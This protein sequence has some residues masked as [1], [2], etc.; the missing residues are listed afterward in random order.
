MRL[1]R[2]VAVFA[3]LV[4]VAGPAHADLRDLAARVAD[5]FRL[6]G[7]E[8]TIAP[9]RFLNDDETANIAL[10]DGPGGPCVSVAILGARGMSFRARLSVD[11]EN[12]SVEEGRTTGAS[13]AGALLLAR[14][15]SNTTGRVV[16]TSNA[17]RGAVEIVVARSKEAMASLTAIIP[18]RG[19]GS[20]LHQ[21]MV[22]PGELPALVP[23][24][25]RA[26]VAEARARRDG[27]TIDPRAFIIATSEGS[28]SAPIVLEPACHR[29]ELFGHE[30]RPKAAGRRGR[31]DLDGDLRDADNELIARDRTDAS[32]AR[33]EACVGEA[34]TGE[35]SYIGSVNA[36][37]VIVTHAR[38]GIPT[39]LPLVWGSTPRAR[40]ASA[41][42]ARHAS[43]P[44]SEAVVVAQ[45]ASGT[46]AVPA[47]IEP[48]ACYIAVAAITHGSARGLGLRAIIGPREIGDERGIGGVASAVAFCAEERDTMRIAVDARGTALAWALAIFRVQGA[49]WSGAR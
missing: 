29:I 3:G 39:R 6:S 9:T 47:T 23:A 30:L 38:W 16:V 10:P 35:V 45:G 31:L 18:E 5:A 33:L 46:T 37:P 34:T 25:T 13:V 4:V 40:M 8:V 43:L 21:H 32:D 1:P 41:L 17:G 20:L 7:A 44:D 11:S 19:G 49:V 36:A 2:A 42:L 28:G 26:D 15:E 12:N 27:A 24:A 22:E 14:C 48:G